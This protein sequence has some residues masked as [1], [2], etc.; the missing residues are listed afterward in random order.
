MTFSLVEVVVEVEGVSVQID[1]GNGQVF[2]TIDLTKDYSTVTELW[3]GK[4]KGYATAYGQTFLTA[5]QS[6]WKW[7]KTSHC[8]C[9]NHFEN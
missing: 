8:E 9:M 7:D 4:I 5:S 1:A 6:V 3:R 2:M